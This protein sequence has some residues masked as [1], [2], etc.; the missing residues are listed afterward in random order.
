MFFMLSIQPLLTQ[1]ESSSTNS[2]GPFQEFLL[3]TWIIAFSTCVNFLL[4]VPT[5]CLGPAKM[6][7]PNGKNQSCYGQLL[8]EVETLQAGS[9]QDD[10]SA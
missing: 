7:H 5:L 3:L 6:E 10:D 2:T 8:D 9:V 4:L 1:T